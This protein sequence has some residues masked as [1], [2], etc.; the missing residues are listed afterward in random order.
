MKA[1]KAK[2]LYLLPFLFGGV[3]AFA[4]NEAT[5]MS[6]NAP[7]VRGE[8]LEPDGTVEK[9][10]PVRKTPRY[11]KATPKDTRPQSDADTAAPL[12]SV[13]QNKG[14]TRDVALTQ[15]LRQ[16]LMKED[17]LSVSAKNVTIITI[18]GV[19]TLKGPVKTDSER[20]HVASLASQIAGRSNVN[21]QL[22]VTP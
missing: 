4:N 9:G 13:D 1:T 17:A 10:T 15:R 3:A 21:N 8:Q 16:D 6:D 2:T 5:T 12:T 14:S 11:Q 7:A 19:M 18:G 22:E 20:K